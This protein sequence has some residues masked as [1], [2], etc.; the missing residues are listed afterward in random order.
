M[1]GIAMSCIHFSGPGV[2]EKRKG[3]DV[4]EDNA[5]AKKR[6]FF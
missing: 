3:G 4:D 1:H 2:C 5:V 6:F